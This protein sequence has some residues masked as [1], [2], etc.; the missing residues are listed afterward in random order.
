M[1]SVTY[2]HPGEQL[3]CQGCHE[4]KH[5]PP[6]ALDTSPLALRRPPS[7]IEPDV[8]GSN[9]FNYV[10]LVQPVLDRKCVTCHEQENAL[11]LSGT[12]DGPH[13]WTRSYTNLGAE[14]GFYFHVSN[15]SINSGV[16]GGSRTIAGQFGARAAKLM[17]YLGPEHYGVQLT[18][19]EL[20][21]VTLWLDCNS[22]FYGSY[23]NTEA[24]ARGEIV[25]P[26]LE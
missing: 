22:E 9:P 7:R 14:Y 4:R 3:T 20:H 2:V 16:H 23:E 5:R 17:E 8:D 11:D 19:D 18:P 12:G 1:R 25:L 21:R 13:G 24:Q 26:T 6:T 15:G 10:R